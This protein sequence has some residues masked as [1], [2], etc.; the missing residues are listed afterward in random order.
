MVG[1]FK[2]VIERLDQVNTKHSAKL[3][4]TFDF[5]T[6]YTKLPHKE[7]LKKLFDLTDFGFNEGSKK[8][9]KFPSKVIFAQTSLK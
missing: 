2:P 8:K 6:L 1:N 3:I 5:N 9:L 7:L 4:S